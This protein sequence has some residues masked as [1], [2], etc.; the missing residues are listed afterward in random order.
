MS[1]NDFF[2]FFKALA[3]ILFK[4]DILVESNRRKFQPLFS[5]A[6]PLGPKKKKIPVFRVTRPNLNLL[7]KPRIFFLVFWKKYNFMQI[8]F[9][10]GFLEK[11]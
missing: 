10:S 4:G 7:A 11:I 3:V 5:P 6:L 2:L 8:G 9:F 1:F